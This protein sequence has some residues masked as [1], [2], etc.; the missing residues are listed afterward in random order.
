MNPTDKADDQPSAQAPA[1]SPVEVAKSVTA[2]EKLDPPETEDTCAKTFADFLSEDDSLSYRSYRVIKLEKTVYEKDS[3]QNVPATYAVLKKNGRKLATFDGVYHPL[4][5]TTGFGL[6]PLLGRGTRQ[7]VISETTPRNGRHWVIDLASGPRVIFDSGRWGLGDED[8]CVHDF[9][10]DGTLEITQA[11]VKF[12]GFGPMSMAESPL[13]GV[14]FRYDRR[15]REYLPDLRRVGDLL[16][17]IEEATGKIDPAENPAEAQTGP[18]LAKR[19]SILLRYLYAGRERAGW[20]FFAR[21]YNRP[22]K[23]EMTNKI[24]AL[25]RDE[26][27]YQFIRARTAARSM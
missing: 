10:R 19:L 8:V 25:L 24:K 23:L 6:A 1:P 17:G 4:R 7:L 26:P 20:S 3:G 15:L 21:T 2:P 9:D 11:V 5:N 14:L 13:P 22:D 16:K 12:W 27:V 18:Y